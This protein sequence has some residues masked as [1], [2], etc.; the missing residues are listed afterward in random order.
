MKSIDELKPYLERISKAIAAEFGD[1]CEVVI[2]DLKKGLDKSI[3]AIEN[4]H[5]TGRAVG[6]PSTNL[7]LEV[8]RGSQDGTDRYGYITHTQNG[9]ILRS[10]SVY[11][12][13]DK[14]DII[15]SL[16]INFDLS[17]ILVAQNALNQL[18]VANQEE[19]VTKEHFVNNI[20]DIVE[21]I[22]AEYMQKNN[23]ILN[24]MSKDDKVKMIKYL[25]SKGVFLVRNSSQR[26]C[27]FLDI[28]KFTLYAIIKKD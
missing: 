20:N 7:G 16:C 22:M 8:M 9:K 28:S 19:E 24:S 17:S 15:G 27:D 23:L 12:E 1:N 11:F 3:V 14:G 5:I 13:N 18:L 26:V 2:H 21:K 25:D 10:S 4:G 6:G